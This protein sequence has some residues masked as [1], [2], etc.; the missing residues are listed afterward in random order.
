MPPEIKEYLKYQPN[1][2][3]LIWIKQPSRG[4][5]VGD[6]AG[7]LNKQGYISITFRSKQY[8]SHRLAYFLHYGV[9][10]N[11][12]EV[13]HINGDRSDNRISNLRLANRSQNGSNQSQAKGIRYR[14][15]EGKWLAKV[16]HKGIEYHLGLFDCPLMARLAYVDMKRE[17]CGEYSPV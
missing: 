16:V 9:D 14:K 7:T 11:D 10:P 17:L 2:G 8:R 4:A 1:T 6:I 5:K 3:E 15:A 13:D 12:K